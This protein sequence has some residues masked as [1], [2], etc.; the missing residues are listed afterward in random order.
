MMSKISNYFSINL[1]GGYM[2]FDIFVIA[3]FVCGCVIL[4]KNSATSR[5]YYICPNCKE[6][7]RTEH[8]NSKRCKVCGTPLNET[9]D[10]DVNDSA[11]DL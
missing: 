6:S 9:F 1:K 11:G 2:L 3:L 10:T 5:R 4:Y 7:F 8:M